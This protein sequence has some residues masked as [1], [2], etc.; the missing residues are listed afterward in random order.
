MAS[1]WL[2][3][4]VC[5]E[6]QLLLVCL[7]WVEYLGTGQPAR[8]GVRGMCVG[9]SS[10]APAEQLPCYKMQL[11]LF[12]YFTQLSTLEFFVSKPDC[13]LL[14]SSFLA[15]TNA[16]AS[17]CAGYVCRTVCGVGWRHMLPCRV[18]HLPS[19]TIVM[20]CTTASQKYLHFGAHPQFFA[21]VFVTSENHR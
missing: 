8:G 9:S 7:S 17:A 2:A 19:R 6:E 14:P 16:H 1:A 11:L 10:P 3:P 5:F 13:F 20:I 21:M 15:S 12:W 4:T 18:H